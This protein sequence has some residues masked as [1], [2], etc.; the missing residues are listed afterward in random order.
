MIDDDGS[1]DIYNDF[2]I[3]PEGTRG[4]FVA[5]PTCDFCHEQSEFTMV[6]PYGSAY[7]DWLMC[8][9]CIKKIVEPA[10]VAWASGVKEE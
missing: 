9:E 5:Y 1:R 2:S 3:I 10:L 6:F 7:D 4:Y 8:V